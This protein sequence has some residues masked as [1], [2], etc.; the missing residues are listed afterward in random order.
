[1]FKWPVYSGRYLGPNASGRFVSRLV[2]TR[3]LEVSR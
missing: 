2:G 1:V 3:L